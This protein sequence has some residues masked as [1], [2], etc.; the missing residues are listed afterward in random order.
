MGQLHEL[1]AVE[2]DLT[3]VSNKVSEE[4]AT[5]FKK[6]AHLFQGTVRTLSMFDAAREGEADVTVTPLSETVNGKLGYISEHISRHYDAVLQKEA[7][8]QNAAADLVVDG[9]VMAKDLPATFLLGMETRLKQLRLVYEAIPTLDPSI[10]WSVD[11][12]AGS[13]VY[14]S[15]ASVKLKTE[16]STEFKVLTVATDKHPAQIDKWVIDKP[17][18]RIETVT[19]S[20]MISPSRK[21][22]LLGRVDTLIRAVKKARQRANTVT[23][24]DRKIGND[25]LGFINA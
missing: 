3:T 12:G 16:K 9:K 7:S 19:Q 5:S 25:I 24:V 4:A 15:D 14:T 8:N 11:E 23:I 17:V 6:K 10:K 21:A 20:G 2:K 22:V 13:D 1:L 18:G